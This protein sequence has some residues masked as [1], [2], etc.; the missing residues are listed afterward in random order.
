MKNI[1]DESINRILLRWDKTRHYLLSLG[2]DDIINIVASI[3]I[4]RR[5]LF[6]SAI[7]NNSV[8]I[9]KNLSIIR[10]LLQKL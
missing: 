7:A 1:G 8:G 4:H 2:G 9:Q 5:K 10:E 6:M 3:E